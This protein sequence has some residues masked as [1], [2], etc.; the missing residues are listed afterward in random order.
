MVAILFGIKIYR[1]KF[2][3]LEISSYLCGVKPI[4]IKSIWK[5]QRKKG[6]VRKCALLSVSIWMKRKS[7]WKKNNVNSKKFMR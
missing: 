1:L 6:L 4:I 5:Q 3:S 7:A 2:G